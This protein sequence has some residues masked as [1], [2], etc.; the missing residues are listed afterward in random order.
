[1]KRDRGGKPASFGSVKMPE[2]SGINSRRRHHR[3]S[4]G[5]K[6]LAR[7]RRRVAGYQGPI[8]YQVTT[9]DPGGCAPAHRDHNVDV[10]SQ[11]SIRDRAS[12]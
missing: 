1:V 6:R 9:I 3:S 12:H 11:T 2:G 4:I 8:D 10:I 5:G 7:R